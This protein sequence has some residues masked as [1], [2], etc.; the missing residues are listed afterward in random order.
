MRLIGIRVTRASAPGAVPGFLGAAIRT[1]LLVLVLPA[2][3][4][5][6]D[7]RGLHDKAAGTIVV[8]AAGS[9]SFAG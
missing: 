6:R 8:R 4:M 1:A 5:D 9:R 7:G 3:L 2:V